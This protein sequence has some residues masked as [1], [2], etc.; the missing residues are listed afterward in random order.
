MK[1][2]L[3]RRIAPPQQNIVVCQTARPKGSNGKL[4]PQNHCSPSK[5]ANGSNGLR[6]GGAMKGEQK[7]PDLQ[8]VVFRYGNRSPPLSYWQQ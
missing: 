1:R 6:V 8:K 5:Y 2:L 4:L 7:V 3:P